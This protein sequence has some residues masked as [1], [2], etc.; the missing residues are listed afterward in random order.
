MDLS[1]LCLQERFYSRQEIAGLLSLNLVDTNHFKR[2]LENKLQKLG[3]GY[4]YSRVGVTITHAPATSEERLR[5]ILISVMNLDAQI[6]PYAFSC[7]IC[8]FDDIPG[9][10]SMP[11]EERAEVFYGFY[12]ICVAHK[13]LS[14][15][16]KRLFNNAFAVKGNERT[17]WKTENLNGTKV[18]YAIAP[19]D[20]GMRLYREELFA[21]IHEYQ[22]DNL[23]DGIPPKEAQQEAWS[24]AIH[25]MWEKYH[26]YY[27]S[28]K[29]ILL[30]AFSADDENILQ[31]I[32]ELTQDIRGKRFRQQ[33]EGFRF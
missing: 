4:E 7:F 3:Y 17:F 30:N 10:E 18:R 1:V 23:R 31:E 6:D 13:T 12:G 25:F 19:D 9:F 2:N 33:P 22:K 5:S 14:N 29:S 8:A 11:W 27:Y 32:Y 24:E 16:C 21:L 28:C 15:W 20:E 26:C